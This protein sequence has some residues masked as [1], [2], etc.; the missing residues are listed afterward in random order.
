MR[1]V[2]KYQV[3]N[4]LR[5]FNYFFLIT[6][7]VFFLLTLI[8]SFTFRGT[9]VSMNGSEI[10]SVVFVFVS[11]LAAFKEHLNMIVQ[12]GRSRRSFFLGRLVAGSIL[13]VLAA[14]GCIL[15]N[16]VIYWFSRLLGAEVSVDM[17]ASLI[18]ESRV[19][20]FFLLVGICFFVFWLGNLI[21]AL[22]SR[23][24]R[25][26]MTVVGFGV[27]SVLLA[28]GILDGYLN[29]GRVLTAVFSFFGN[30]FSSWAANPYLGLFHLVVTGLVLWALS[31]PLIRRVNITGNQ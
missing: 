1:A 22:F 29:H 10:S 7:G 11:G 20:L 21:I 24:N 27:P 28:I 23:L 17:L 30:L 19:G 8:F 14:G 6:A 5:G 25:I 9:E 3:N 4:I 16:A 12:L 31:W 15:L 13:S 26:Q 2:V 18:S